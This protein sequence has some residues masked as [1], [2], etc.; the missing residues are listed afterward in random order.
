MSMPQKEF[1]L[2]YLLVHVMACEVEEMIGF[3]DYF[4]NDMLE[5][6][7][8]DVGELRIGGGVI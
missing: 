5:I 4:S 1:V 6:V 8:C 7:C 2:S 3:I